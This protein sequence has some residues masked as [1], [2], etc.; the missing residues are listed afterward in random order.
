MFGCLRSRALILGALLLVAGPARSDF[1]D[2]P[3]ALRL[4]FAVDRQSNYAST[5]AR[6]ASIAALEGGSANPICCC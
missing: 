3:F 6:Q 5:L 4:F 1:F 2:Q